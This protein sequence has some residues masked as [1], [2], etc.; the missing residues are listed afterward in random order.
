MMTA[1]DIAAEAAGAI[2][3]LNELTSDGADFARLDDVREVIASLRR[4]SQDLPHLCEQLARILVAQREDGLIT[5]APGQDPD[6]WVAEAVEALAAAG[7]TADMLA[8][9]LAQADKTS[10]ELRSSSAGRLGEVDLDGD[11][12]AQRLPNRRGGGHLLVQVGHGGVIGISIEVDGHSDGGEA[13]M[14]V[15]QAEEGVQ[16]DVTVKVD[17]QI[18]DRD[19]RHGGVGGIAD[20]EAVAQRA[21]KLLDRVRRAVGTAELGGLVR[22]DRREAPD[23]GLAAEGSGPPHLGGPRGEGGRGALLDLVDQ[24]AHGTQVDLVELTIGGR[25]HAVTLH[26]ILS[27][28]KVG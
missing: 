26:S 16:V 20:R 24:R 15:G 1:R 4:M 11:R 12:L 3:A 14:P 10:A 19:A 23:Q 21:E 28:V 8:A 25:R 18:V 2:R 5:P 6:F 27:I 17:P 22:G 13:G 7:Q 9:A